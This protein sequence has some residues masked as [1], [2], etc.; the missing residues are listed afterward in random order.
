MGAAPGAADVDCT[1]LQLSTAVMARAPIPQARVLRLSLIAFIAVSFKDAVI[2]PMHFI[3][4]LVLYM[5]T[6][7]H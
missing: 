6:S 4:V 1:K 2:C 5:T 3:V 7:L